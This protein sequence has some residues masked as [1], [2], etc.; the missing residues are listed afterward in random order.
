MQTAQEKLVAAYID[1]IHRYAEP[2]DV[3]KI[4][5]CFRAIP[6][7][8]AKENRKFKYGEVEKGGTARKYFSCVEWL[9][10]A[11]LVSRPS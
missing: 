9:K 10:D 6:R 8:L 7:I 3:P 11:W 5:G 2:V 4:E 1:D